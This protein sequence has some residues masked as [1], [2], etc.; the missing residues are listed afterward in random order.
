MTAGHWPAQRRAGQYD[1]VW[2][3]LG[4]PREVE[5]LHRRRATCHAWFWMEDE[6]HQ[7]GLP[8]ARVRKWFSGNHSLLLTFPLSASASDIGV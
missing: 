8:A 5:A 2:A 7:A 1:R 6:L 3:N 4:D